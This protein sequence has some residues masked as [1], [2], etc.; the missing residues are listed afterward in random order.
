VQRVLAPPEDP[1]GLQTAATCGD[2][3]VQLADDADGR[4][5]GGGEGV[6]EGVG[7]GQLLAA[8][9]GLDLPCARASRLRRRA[10]AGERGA[11]LRQRQPGALVWGRGAAQHREGV[12]V[13]QHVEG[14]QSGRVVRAIPSA[15][16]QPS[17]TGRGTI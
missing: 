1:T 16:R 13:V 5:G 17:P 11:D 7:C 12:A 10:A 8:Q 14:L 9:R 2:L 6:P 3:A 15:L 4:P